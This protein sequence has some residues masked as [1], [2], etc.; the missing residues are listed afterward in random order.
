MSLLFNPL[1]EELAENRSAQLQIIE[2][3]RTK[4]WTPMLE[5]ALLFLGNKETETLKNLHA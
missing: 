5:N 2:Q 4:G 1:R 3:A